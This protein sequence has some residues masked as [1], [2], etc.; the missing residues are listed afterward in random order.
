MATFVAFLRAINVGG[1]GMLPMKELSALCVDLGLQNVRTYIQSGNVVF[2]S[3]LS[4][5]QIKTE[6]E[7]ALAE[8]MGKAVDV[9]VRAASE[10]RAILQANPF[11]N[12]KP[13]QVAVIFLADPAPKGLLDNLVIPGLEE[14]QPANREIYIHYPDGMGRSKLKLPAAAVGTARNLN[15]IAKLVE[16]TEAMRGTRQ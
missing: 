12:G 2:K 16:M 6:L 9:V 8:K 11:P 14:V 15:T 13:A 5:Q 10:L 7:Q 4:E 1:T 3:P